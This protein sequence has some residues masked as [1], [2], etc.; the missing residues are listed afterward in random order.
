MRRPAFFL[1]YFE[2]TRRC[3]Q[4][5][6]YC[7]TRR[8]GT[9]GGELSTEEVKRLVLDGMKE[10]CPQGAVSF[11]GGEILLRPDHLELIAHNAGNGLYTFVNTSGAGL[12]PGKVRDLKRA[13]GG[14][15]TLG[16]SLD[17]VRPEVH[18]RCRSGGP[19]RIEDLGRICAEQGV[20]YFVLVTVSRRNLAT[21]KDTLEWLQRRKIPMIRSPFVPRGAAARARHLCFDREDM[22]EV[23]HPALQAVPL[24][25]VSFVPFFADPDLARL[26]LGGRGLSLG[27]LG[28]QAGRTYIGIS[29][30]G[31]VAPC[32][33]LLDTEVRCGNVRERSLLRILE[34][35][36]ILRTLQ[37]QRP[38]G[39]KCARCRYGD[40]CR[41]CRALAYYH[42]GDWRAEDPTCFF[43]PADLS[44]RSPHEEEQT[45]NARAF[46]NYLSRQPPWREIFGTGGRLGL[47]L[48]GLREGVRRWAGGLRR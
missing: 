26:R 34:E 5:C 39:G 25:Y 28:C 45:R 3:D 40:S 1:C 21:L 17:S 16:F 15:L 30:E 22:R 41:G 37:G 9:P 14:R 46:L 6:P 31:E 10:V 35:S 44:Q 20:P 29:A 47:T 4:D 19:G 8:N 38:S 12:D 23:I 32:V 43:D 42:S 13:A 7:M 48:L 33:H 18:A 24:S 27:N 11:S 2:A 36:P